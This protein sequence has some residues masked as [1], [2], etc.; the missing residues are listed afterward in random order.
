[1]ASSSPIQERPA[2]QSGFRRSVT[3]PPRSLSFHERAGL[4]PSDSAA[5]ILYSHLAARIIKFSPPYSAI[6]S[7]SS[8]IS[9]DLD[10][11]VDTVETLPW[12]STTETTVASGL[13]IIEKVQGSTNFLKCGAVMHAI[14]R[15]SQCWCVDGES[16][17]VLR[18]QKFQ[19]YRIELPSQ[20][21]EE[22][23]RIQALKG[24]L[25]K[26]SRFE[27]TPCPFKRAFH[28]ELPEEATTPRRK[29]TWKRRQSSVTSTPT[30]SI[31]SPLGSGR[32]WKRPVSQT[33]DQSP[34]AG[35]EERKGDSSE[36]DSDVENPAEDLHDIAQK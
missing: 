9:Q 4:D 10:Y 24:C 32:C 34:R 35:E 22:R 14:M 16:K 25:S 27:K 31:P 11:P 2:F 12:A 15:N 20:T 36:M 28:V 26:I 29:G 33:A 13:M 30:S 23:D 21:Q 7:V 17:F 5:D 1:M 19:Y 6:R 18:I 8:P 3:L